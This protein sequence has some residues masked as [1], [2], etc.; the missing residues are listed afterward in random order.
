MQLLVL[1]RPR[2]SRE[3][4]GRVTIFTLDD[5]P[6]CRRAKKLLASKGT[7]L[8]EISLTESPDCKSLMFLLMLVAQECDYCSLVPRLITFKHDKAWERGYSLHVL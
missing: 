7:Q 3:I 1:N 2:P 8:Q 5:C 6:Y 4:K